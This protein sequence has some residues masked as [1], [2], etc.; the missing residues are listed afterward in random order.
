MKI[1][2]V[3]LKTNKILTR[4]LRKKYKLKNKDGIKNKIFDKL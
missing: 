2:R 4:K 1:M 3:K